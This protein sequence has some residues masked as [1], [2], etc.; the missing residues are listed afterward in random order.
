M[1]P[2]PWLALS[3]NEEVVACPTVY[4]RPNPDIDPIIL[5]RDGLITEKAP[6]KAL[7]IKTPCIPFLDFVEF[8]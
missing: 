7:R 3:I 5:G 2:D 4:V 6:S 8:S 1:L